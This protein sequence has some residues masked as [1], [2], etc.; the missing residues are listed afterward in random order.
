MITSEI[1]S[2]RHTGITDIVRHLKTDMGVE[3][4]GRTVH[5]A[6]HEAGSSPVKKTKG[7]R[8]SIENINLIFCK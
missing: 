6:L 1:T 4:S 2:D 8:Y 3:V 7:Y 5:N